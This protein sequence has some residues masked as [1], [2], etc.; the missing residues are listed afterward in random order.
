MQFGVEGLLRADSAGRAASCNTLLQNGV[1]N[2][3]EVRALENRAFNPGGE[4]Y[5]VQ[6]KSELS[7]STNWARRL[8]PG[9]A[10]RRRKTA[11]GRV[12]GRPPA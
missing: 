4:I 6:A 8:N 11:L 12:A 10:Q 2:R 7:Q 1:F 9:R 3:N 5:T